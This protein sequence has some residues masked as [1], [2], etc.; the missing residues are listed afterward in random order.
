MVSRQTPS[1]G[2]LIPLVSLFLGGRV[3]GALG[4]VRDRSGK[5][6]QNLNKWL[7]RDCPAAGRDSGRRDKTHILECAS[8]DNV[9]YIWNDEIR[10]TRN[11]RCFLG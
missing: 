11:E 3:D 10:S 8:N 5:A 9:S 6:P 2:P 4:D 1:S 7:L